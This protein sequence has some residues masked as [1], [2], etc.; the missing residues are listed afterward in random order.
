MKFVCIDDGVPPES[1]AVLGAACAKRRVVFERVEAAGFDYLPERQLEPGDMLYCP[2]VSER[3]GAVERFLYTP[4]VADLRRDRLGPF[5]AV[6]GTPLIFSRHGLP[7]PRQCPAGLAAI[8]LLERLVEELGGFPVVVKAPGGSGGIGVMRAD[9]MPALASMVEFLLA[10][11]VLPM[12]SSFVADAVCWRVVVV[13]ERAV[14]AC[15]NPVPS[16]DFRSGQADRPEDYVAAIPAQ[17]AELAVAAVRLLRLEFGGV[18]ILEHASGR[19]YLLE[20]NFP[21]YFA[22]ADQIGGADIAGAMLDH[23]IKKRL[24]LAAQV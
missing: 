24:R 14:C 12:L 21:C 17:L 5:A 19:L 7:T 20:A 16:G 11:G 6:G 1:F 3:A 10:K 2:A 18:D 9:S 23:L 13:G 22:P 8:A 15:R 4:G